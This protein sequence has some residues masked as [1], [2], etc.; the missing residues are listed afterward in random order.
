[1]N[2]EEETGRVVARVLAGDVDA[3]GTLV[4]RHELGIRAYM[5]VR[6]D[7]PH[8]AEDLAQEVFLIAFRKLADFD[9]SRPMSAWLRGIASNVLR[10][11]LRKREPAQAPI[12]E[13][14][15]EGAARMEEDRGGGPIAQA[16]ERCL[17]HL[18]PR[19]RELVERRYGRGDSVGDICRDLQRQHS[20]VTMALHRIRQ[21]LRQCVERR[22]TPAGGG[23]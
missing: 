11:R 8:E 10:N 22:L 13:I 16:L 7:D 23:A 19:A 4:L 17:E 9:V 3:F 18:E 15:E 12:P 14:L 1:M 21:Q 6:L 2:P 5:A 20:S